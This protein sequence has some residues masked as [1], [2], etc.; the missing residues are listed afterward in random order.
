[1]QLAE[2]TPVVLTL[3]EM[4]NVE[5][6]LAPLLWA[7]RVVVVD[8]FST[9][10]TL[11]ACRRFRNVEV[12]QRTFDNH[13]N[14]WNFGIGLVA[15]PWALS[16][17]ADYIVSEALVSELRGVLDPDVDAYFAKFTYCV[18]G[19]P[20]QGSLYPPRAIL[21]RPDRAR[22]VQ[23]G[24]TQRLKVDGVCGWLTSRVLH[25][26]R[27]PISRWLVDQV[28][29]SAQEAQHLNE[30]PIS[31][32]SMPDRIRRG[33][34]LAPPLFFLYALIGQRALLDGWSGCYY[35]GQRALAELLLSLR[36]LEGRL[37]RSA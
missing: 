30:T 32:L 36:L 25:D 8:S 17:D 21:F 28:R 1:M 3:N 10:G 4:P 15:T 14:Q 37:R 9:D 33:I 12:V 19:R 27:K 35:A 29:Y 34:V 16:L 11:E 26:D 31:A 23:D 5:R 7:R 13:A 22:Y 6:M 20:L 2:V 18:F 24:H